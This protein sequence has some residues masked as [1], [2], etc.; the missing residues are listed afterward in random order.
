M[1]GIEIKNVTKNFGKVCAVRDVSLRFEADSI[2]GLLGRN[3]A[4][5]TTL[6]NMISNRLFPDRGEITINGEPA[7]EN[8]RAQGNLFLMSEGNFYPDS[9]KVKTA[10]EWTAKLYPGFDMES[11]V[12]MA[13]L[14]GLDTNKKTK[15]LSTGYSSIFKIIT[16]LSVPTPYVLLDEPVLGLDANHRDLFYKTLL[17]EY[18]KRPRC[19]V[20]ST[21]L[22]EEAAGIIEKIII[23]KS[24]EIMENTTS[25][26]LLSQ[27]YTASGKRETVDAY[28]AGRRVIGEDVLGG[29]KSVYIMEQLDRAEVPDNIEISK[30]DLQK[31]FIQLTNS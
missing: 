12:S 11:A 4:G 2:Y 3:G 13:A 5:K 10:L 24:G 22:I 26:N 1:N 20:I 9:M 29:L 31:L 23:I 15:A 21:H 27:G 28:A 16:A 7:L 8:D 17:M 30:L 6:L 14:F 25:E 19:F 18:E